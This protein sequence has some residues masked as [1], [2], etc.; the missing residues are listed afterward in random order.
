MRRRSLLGIGVAGAAA[1]AG[2]AW[3]LRRHDEADPESEALWHMTLPRPDGGT[4]SM[5]A[6]RG[7]PLL[8]NFWATW[9]APCVKEMPL[10][11]L[12]YRE[13]RSAGW[14]VVGLAVD[15]A[16]PVREFLGRLPVGFPVGL[17][18]ME[19]ATLS[20]RLGN[21]AGGL[22]FTV[23][24]NRSGRIHARKLGPISPDELRQWA[25][26]LDGESPSA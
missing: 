12:F 1:A 15:S 23:V 8:L 19:G 9:C 3:S 6:L 26:K 18:G 21:E 10:L 11:D 25:E 20:R 4:L 7:R 5:S 13:H 22:P 17:A 24:F 14:Q 2:L 16:A